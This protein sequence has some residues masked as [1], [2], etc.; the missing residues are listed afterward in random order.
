MIEFTNRPTQNRS[1]RD[2]VKP[3]AIVLHHTGG[4][5]KGDLLWL[6]SPASRVSADFLIN[7]KGLIYKLNPDLTIF[8]TYHAGVS[9]LD[10]CIRKNNSINISTIGIEMSHRTNQSWPE[11][12]VEA[13][14][15]LC[16]WL[17]ASGK[18]TRHKIVSHRE[19]AIPFGRKTDPKD[20]PWQQ[21]SKFYEAQIH[22]LPPNLL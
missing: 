21:F 9:G 10:G 18:V 13:C 5:E 3:A 16:W 4:S 8:Y 12:Q 14:A 6:T 22:H 2:G 20:F 19:V 15:K 11:A 1:L 17:E 7:R